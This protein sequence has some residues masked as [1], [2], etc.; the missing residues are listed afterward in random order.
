[1]CLGGT[2]F[3]APACLCS[4]LTG[5]SSIILLI[6]LPAPFGSPLTSQGTIFLLIALRSIL[7]DVFAFVKIVKKYVAIAH[8]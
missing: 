2:D 3:I 7:V 4:P 5:Q 8:R 1:M 6:A